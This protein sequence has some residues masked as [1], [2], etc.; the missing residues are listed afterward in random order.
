GRVGVGSRSEIAEGEGYV[1]LVARAPIAD[2]LDVAFVGEHA[3]FAV[4]RGENAFGD[5]V[6]AALVGPAVAGEVGYRDHLELVNFADLYEV[7][8]AGHGTVFVH[9][10]ADDASGDESGHACEI[11]RS[12]GLAGADD[13]SAFGG[14]QG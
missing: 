11:D 7:G 3:E 4:F 12:F 14:A 10:L 13:A 6:D 1:R 8:N 5:A 2:G 9:D